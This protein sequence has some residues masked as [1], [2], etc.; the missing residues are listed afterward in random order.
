MNLAQN[1]R[2]AY[3]ILEGEAVIVD[4]SSSMLYSLN[5]VATLVWEVSSEGATVEEIVDR[6]MDEFEVERAVAERDCLEFAQDLVD[7]GLLV[8]TEEPKEN[9]DGFTAR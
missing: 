4:P 8:V 2:T 3:R 5:P 1:S 9:Q 6:V 7:R